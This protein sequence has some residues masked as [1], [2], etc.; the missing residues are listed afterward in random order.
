MRPHPSRSD[1]GRGSRFGD[2]PRAP[3]DR[4]VRIRSRVLA[5]AVLLLSTALGTVACTAADTHVPSPSPTAD[6][7]APTLPA[8]SV[9]AVTAFGGNCDDV[10]SPEQVNG[11]VD[12]A[13]L[14][15][16]EPQPYPPSELTG[17]LG[18]VWRSAIPG[19][20]LRVT[21]IPADLVPSSVA[22][23]PLYAMESCDAFGGECVRSAV[24]GG[25]WLVADVPPADDPAAA[26]AV[27]T[28]AL[29]LARSSAEAHPGASPAR[30]GG[31]WWT[32]PVCED[33]N[34]SVD[35]AA[36]LDTSVVEPVYYSDNVPRG[37]AW[38]STVAGGFDVW[39]PW[40][41]WNGEIGDWSHSGPVVELQVW[42]GGGETAAMSAI[43][44][45]YGARAVEVPGADRA[46]ALPGDSGGMRLYVVTGPNA[47]WV[48][49]SVSEEILVSLAAAVLPVLAT[50]GG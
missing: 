29:A 38:E 15:T 25:M 26:L 45:T 11:L 17:I 47:M 3:Y 5:A 9:P 28:D 27:A 23:S 44:R 19:Q 34:A 43:F 49:G 7:P 46:V 2:A 6:S 1:N 35:V 12:G 21:A 10:L 18:C 41:G 22:D 42:P 16:G 36:A 40:T 13:T 50:T 24:A 30:P 33:L 31:D 20:T 14:D 32:A 48:Y 39:C 37:A 8:A 4:D